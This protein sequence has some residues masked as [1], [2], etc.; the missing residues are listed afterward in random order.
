MNHLSLIILLLPLL[1]IFILNYKLFLSLARLVPHPSLISLTYLYYSNQTL[2]FSPSCYSS[3]LN[4]I[5]YLS[6]IF[7]NLLLL[8]YYYYY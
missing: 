3:L 5:V 4:E 8:L 7:L 2:I 1:C 6:F